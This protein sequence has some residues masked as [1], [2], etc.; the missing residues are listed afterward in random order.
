MF[1]SDRL[2]NVNVTLLPDLCNQIGE[3]SLVIA[4]RNDEP[5]YKNKTLILKRP[6]KQGKCDVEA[7]PIIK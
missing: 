5:N 7:K 1:T 4:Y 3:I 6:R 2:G